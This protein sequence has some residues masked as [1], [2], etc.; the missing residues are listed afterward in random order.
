MTAREMTRT[1]D[2][3][4]GKHTGKNTGKNTGTAT[5]DYATGIASFARSK[6]DK[7]TFRRYHSEPEFKGGNVGTEIRRQR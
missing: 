2:R 6:A 3:H 5:Q 4:E 1:K 7:W